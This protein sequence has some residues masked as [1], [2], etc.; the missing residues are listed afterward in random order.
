MESACFVMKLYKT[1]AWCKLQGLNAKGFKTHFLFKYVLMC[2]T[3]QI[4]Q[5]AKS[6]GQ[7]SSL[8][9]KTELSPWNMQK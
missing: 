7:P 6:V 5:C 2:S 1:Q 9:E 8:T 4:C 3:S